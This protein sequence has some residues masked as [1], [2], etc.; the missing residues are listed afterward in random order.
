GPTFPEQLLEVLG[1]L[2]EHCVDAF[3][4]LPGGILRGR[5]L[6]VLQGDAEPIGQPLDRADEVE[7]LHLLDEAD[8]VAAAL[9]AETLVEAVRAVH[10]EAWRPL[11]VEWTAAD[12]ARSPLAQR[13][14]LRDDLDDVSPLLDLFDGAVLDP[15]HYSA[16]AY[17]SA[18]RSVMPAM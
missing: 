15:R 12:E 18:N 4:L 6:L 9:A 2:L 8:R 5:G 16:A 7:P 11:L 1:R 17:A 3:P 13:R 10:R 14:V